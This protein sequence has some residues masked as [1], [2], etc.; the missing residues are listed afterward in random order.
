[1]NNAQIPFRIG[2]YVKI[3]SPH[4]KTV[5]TGDIRNILRDR[6]NWPWAVIVDSSTH[7]RSFSVPLSYLVAT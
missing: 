1:M 6:D 3:R 5:L 7:V 2:D 4:N